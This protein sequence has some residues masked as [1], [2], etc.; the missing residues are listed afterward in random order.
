VNNP[1]RHLRDF[2][3]VI[4][5]VALVLAVE[6]IIDA[7]EAG[8]P[9]DWRSVPLFVAFA[10]LAF[11]YYHGSARYLDVMYSP[12]GPELSKLRISSDLLIG[13]IDMM[14]LIALSILT[15][16]P[17][18][19]VGVVV[20]LFVF[21]FVRVVILKRYLPDDQIFRLE[22]DF[23]VIHSV[24]V[25]VLIIILLVG[26]AIDDVESQRLIVGVPVMIL[27]SLRSIL[28]YRRSFELYFPQR[29]PEGS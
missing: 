27:M 6:G 12:E 15:S 8:S 19:F 20:V 18:Y 13:A 4:L 28:S 25:P 16:R 1:G 23:Q 11:S 24:L 3:A 10:A 29:R 17:L 21:E 7:A 22:T 9:I 14:L 26:R 5:G 2:Y